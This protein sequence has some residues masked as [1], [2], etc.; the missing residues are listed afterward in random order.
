ME[1][2]DCIVVGDPKQLNNTPSESV[3]YVDPFVKKLN[4][5]YPHIQIE[6]YDERFTSKM[7]TQAIRDA[8]LKKKD[9]ENK[10]MIDKVSAVILLQSYMEY[11][12][13]KKR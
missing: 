9:R 5:L 1:N 12:S 8:G 7:A 11:R 6:K 2:V 13:A 3:K 4:L 10:S